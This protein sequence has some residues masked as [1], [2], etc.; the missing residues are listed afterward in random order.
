VRR[1]RVGRE[2]CSV[3]GAGGVVRSMVSSGSL[4]WRGGRTTSDRPVLIPGTE[5]VHTTSDSRKER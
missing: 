1:I 3:A 4:M 2:G 5:L